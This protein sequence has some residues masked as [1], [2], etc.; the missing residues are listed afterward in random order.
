MFSVVR[1]FFPEFP[2]KWAKFPKTFPT[3]NCLP[4]FWGKLD[5]INKCYGLVE[6]H[7]TFFKKNY[8][9]RKIEITDHS[10]LFH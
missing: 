5:F 4:Y 8:K 2:G 9:I 3:Q 1:N 6:K 7:P 10:T